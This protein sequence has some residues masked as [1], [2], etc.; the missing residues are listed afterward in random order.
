MSGPLIKPIRGR[1]YLRLTASA[2][3][4][5]RIP[6]K[7]NA[8]S[9]G[10]VNGIPSGRRSVFGAQ[11]RW[12]VDCAGSVRLRQEKVSGAQRRKDAASG[13]RGA[14]KGAAALFPASA[15]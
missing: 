14:G 6:A 1:C 8:D 5:V 11:R 9:E 13:E 15:L 10:N 3:R 4:S 2:I 7:V 12:Q